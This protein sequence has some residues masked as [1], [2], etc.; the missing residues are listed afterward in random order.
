M[1]ILLINFL[2][3]ILIVVAHAPGP[4]SRRLASLKAWPESR[5]RFPGQ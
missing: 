1:K 2:G 3:S 5:K 4:L